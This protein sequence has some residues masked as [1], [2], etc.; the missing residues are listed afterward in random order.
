MKIS[1][2][3][4]VAQNNVIGGNNQLMWHLP[5]DMRFFMKTTEGHC[6]LTGRLNYESIPEKFR[7]LKKRTN[8]VVTRQN[9]YSEE[10]GQLK[11]VN[12]IDEG[13]QLARD[14]Q[15]KELFIIGGGE[16]YRQTLHLT[17]KL[18]ITEVKQKFEGDTVFPSF[19][20]SSWNEVSRIICSPDSEN[21]Y[22]MHFVEFERK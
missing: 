12:N 7:P 19:D 18:Y 22:E 8:I 6:I 2:I 14:L 4:A 15:E 16:I 9:N 20:R 10:T 21:A 5:L 11:I 13:I 1:I 3:A 17:D